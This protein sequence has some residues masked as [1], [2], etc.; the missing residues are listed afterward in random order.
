[1]IVNMKITLRA[2]LTVLLILAVL[3][4]IFILYKYLYLS[5]NSA[6]EMPPM[7]VKTRINLPDYENLK[8]RV[9]Q[10]ARYQLPA[11]SLQGDLYGR[12]NPFA[13]Y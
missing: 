2:V 11:Y 6:P 8:K 7:T 12:E 10:N 5:L 1:M 4:E 3:A 9:E 13:E